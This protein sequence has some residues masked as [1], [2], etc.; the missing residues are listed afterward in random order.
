MW[1]PG[2][3]WPERRDPGDVLTRELATYEARKAEFLATHPGEFVL[4]HG[5]E[6][7]GFWAN[8]DDA[9]EVGY[10]RFGLVPLLLKQVVEKEPVIFLGGGTCQW[11]G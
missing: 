3:E 7:V 11:R 5:D 6:V 2:C 4:I 10:S 1:T 9:L 8:E